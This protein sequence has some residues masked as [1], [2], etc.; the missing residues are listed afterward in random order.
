MNS[1][2]IAFDTLLDSSV[3]GTIFTE[4]LIPASSW[5]M[6]NPDN[7]LEL[8]LKENDVV[9]DLNQCH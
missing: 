5:M 2:Y 3:D 8:A 7:L 4:D 1:E 9:S 6:K